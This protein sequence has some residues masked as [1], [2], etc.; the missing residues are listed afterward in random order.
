MNAEITGDIEL[1][2]Y[3]DRITTCISLGDEKYRYSQTL[4]EFRQHIIN[5]HRALE[6][7]EQLNTSEAKNERRD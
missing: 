4:H 6:M 7:A 2:I 5:S 1:L 3:P